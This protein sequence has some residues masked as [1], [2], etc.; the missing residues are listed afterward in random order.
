MQL[1]NFKGLIHYNINIVYITKHQCMT[2]NSGEN[3]LNLDYRD[4]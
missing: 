1:Y 2:R 3:I 4:I